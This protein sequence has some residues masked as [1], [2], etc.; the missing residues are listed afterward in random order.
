MI[1]N[2]ESEKYYQSGNE[3]LNRGEYEK[4]IEELNEAIAA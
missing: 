2:E 1:F 4:A 3:Y